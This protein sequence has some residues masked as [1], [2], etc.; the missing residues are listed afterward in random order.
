MSMKWPLLMN[1]KGLWAAAT[2]AN[3]S[4]YMTESGKF[5]FIGQKDVPSN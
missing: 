2:G 3:Q 4:G 5:A 1:R